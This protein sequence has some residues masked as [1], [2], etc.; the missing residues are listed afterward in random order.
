MKK[1]K[2]NTGDKV[3]I[4]NYGHIA[5][6]SI[7]DEISLG[8]PII[9]E[10]GNMRAI[11]VSPELVGK[12]AII[13]EGDDDFGYSLKTKKDKM[14]WFSPDQLEMITPNPNRL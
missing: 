1:A 5:I 9:W 3:R 7:H 6:E 14:A 10:R 11:D 13:T 8:G 12:K 2:F 4:V